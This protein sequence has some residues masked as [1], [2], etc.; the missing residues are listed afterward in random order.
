MKS[1][2]CH[3]WNATFSM[4]LEFLARW[5]SAMFPQDLK[6]SQNVLYRRVSLDVVN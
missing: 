1:P 2:C 3:L 4:T 6:H 5:K